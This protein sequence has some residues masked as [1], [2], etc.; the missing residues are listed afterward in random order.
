M[1]ELRPYESIVIVKSD[2]TEDVQKQIFK[3]TKEIIATHGGDLFS[4]ETWGRR[5]LGNV[6]G[7][8]RKGVFFHTTF[9]ADTKAV[10]EIER[11]MKINDNVL[12]FVH[13]RL[14]EGTTMAGYQEAFK[15]SLVEAGLKEKEREEKIRQK[16]AA[17]A[18]ASQG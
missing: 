11:V 2:S 3:K 4:V 12:R 7:K 15:K 9:T 17:R 1:S 8:S 18:Q 10:S 14:P 5:Q 13:T 16:K 6:I